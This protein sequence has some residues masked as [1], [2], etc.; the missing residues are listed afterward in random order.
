MKVGTPKEINTFISESHLN[1]KIKI[2]RIISIDNGINNFVIK[3]NT[4]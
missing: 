4:C 3:K 1:L 2:S